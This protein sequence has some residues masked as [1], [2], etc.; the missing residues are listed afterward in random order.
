MSTKKV[1]PELYEFVK[2]NGTSVK[3]NENSA[4]Y[5]LEFGWLPRKEYDAKIAAPKV[6]PASIEPA[7]VLT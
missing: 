2:Q 3:I 5:A 1:K 4:P 7:P 6:A